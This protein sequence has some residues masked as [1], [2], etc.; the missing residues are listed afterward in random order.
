MNLK[1]VRQEF[2]EESTIGSLFVNDEFFDRRD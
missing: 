1:L 2:T